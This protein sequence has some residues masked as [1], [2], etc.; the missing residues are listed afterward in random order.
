MIRQALF[1]VIVNSRSA[2]L[3]NAAAN[4]IDEAQVQSWLAEDLFRRAD[5]PA[6]MG[7]ESRG[8]LAA[9]ARDDAHAARR[10]EGRRRRRAGGGGAGGPG[11]PAGVAEEGR[12]GATQPADVK[13]RLEQTLARAREDIAAGAKEIGLDPAAADLDAQLKAR[14]DAG[15]AL[16]D[17]ASSRSISRR[18]RREW[19]QSLQRDRTQPV[20]LDERLSSAAYAE[21]VRQ[22][23]DLIRARDLHL[24]A[25]A[26]A[27]AGGAGPG[28]PGRHG[29]SPR[30]TFD[31]CRGRR[32][33][34]A[35]GA[36]DQPPPAATHAPAEELKLARD[37]GDSRRGWRCSS[38][39]DG[40]EDS[41]ASVRRRGNTT[42]RHSPFAPA[43]RRRRGTT[44]RPRNST[45]CSRRLAAVG[46]A[47]PATRRRSRAAPVLDWHRRRRSSAT[48]R[49]GACR[50]AP[51]SSTPTSRRRP[52]W[53]SPT[54]CIGQRHR[55]IEHTVRRAETI[56]RLGEDQQRLAA[57]TDDGETEASADLG[58]AAARGRG[59]DRARGPAGVAAVPGATAGD[60]AP[61]PTRT[62]AGGRRR[63]CWRRRR[64]W[65]RCRSSSRRRRRRWRAVA[66]GG[67]AGGAGAARRR[68]DAGPVRQ[69][70]AVRAAAQADRD[71]ADA[72]KR[73]RGAPPGRSARPPS[74]NSRCASNRSRRRADG[75][76]DVLRRGAAA[77]AAA[78]G[79]R[80]RTPATPPRSR[81]PPTRRGSRSR[82]R[83]GN[84]RSR[85]RR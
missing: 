47:A 26:A 10:A 68:R 41:R 5:A 49:P 7:S 61:R 6:G 15:A 31:E 83:R 14:V 46:T 60:A 58:G 69:P 55:E 72:A 75:A 67:R 12:G 80:V 8:L 36:R 71:A 78:A 44:R 16:L 70:A 1:R 82:R 13:Q 42:W 59:G 73:F 30:S 37:G 38:V 52:Q 62:G 18:R 77:G 24:A 19:A 84:C 3:S 34:A 43:P 33:R 79:G 23:A 51:T 40:D 21:A 17:G 29:S 22:D 25:R 32:R 56:D 2:E 20:V 65:P 4:W 28:G 45:R 53:R 48:L 64:R 54:A 35:A 57:E 74:S 27:R 85:R 81:A 66:R 50:R 63:R 9:L 11:E 76:C 39:G